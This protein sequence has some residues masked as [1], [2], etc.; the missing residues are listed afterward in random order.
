M[1]RLTKRF[2]FILSS[3]VL[4]ANLF[5]IQIG[6]FTERDLAIVI[7]SLLTIPLTF[8]CLKEVL[9]GPIWLISWVLPLFFTA[10]VGFFY[11]LLP[12]S[13]FTALPILVFYFL[14]MY[15]ILLS[16]NIF[17]VSA[18]RTIQLY[19]AAW[20][21]GF[22][23]SLLVSFFLFDT[24]FSLGL[25]FYYNFWFIFLISFFLFLH[26]TWSVNLEEM[27]SGK[28]WGHAF[29]LALGIGQTAL[30]IS[31]WPASITLRSL[32][33]TSLIYVTLGL[34]QAKLTDRL[35]KKTVREYLLVGF[36]VFAILFFY[37]TW[38]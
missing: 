20:A 3:C 15:S 25:P 22:L 33:L 24:V 19:R 17:S 31:F 4:T 28:V 38:G 1:F 18:I 21:V 16:E 14:G 32:F 30:M 23:L 29:V 36:S 8:W 7:L 5:A 27:L 13:F 6:F 26:G 11:F 35:F 9:K 10:G 34:T 12:S 37:T 2:K